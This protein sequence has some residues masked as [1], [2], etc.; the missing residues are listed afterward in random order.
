MT[1][2]VTESCFLKYLRDIIN[3]E[4]QIQSLPNLEVT[5]LSTQSA[6]PEDYVRRA[7]LF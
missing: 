3:P 1:T 6:Q 5:P 4:A 7:G 2:E